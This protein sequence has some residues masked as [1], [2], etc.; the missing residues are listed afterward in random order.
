MED[1]KLYAWAYVTQLLGNIKPKLLTLL[2]QNSVID[3]SSLLSFFYQIISLHHVSTLKQQHAS[4]SCKNIPERHMPYFCN[5]HAHQHRG[6]RI[7]CFPVLQE[8]NWSPPPPEYARLE[9]SAEPFW[10][11]WF[12][13]KNQTMVCYLLGLQDIPFDMKII[14]KTPHIDYRCFWK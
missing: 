13:T 2:Y 5:I 10:K 4:W 9:W 1:T 7:L 3:D 12:Y 8:S 14:T 11:W 6:A